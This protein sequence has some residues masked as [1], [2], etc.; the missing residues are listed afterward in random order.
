MKPTREGWDWSTKLGLGSGREAGLLGWVLGWGLGLGLGLCVLPERCAAQTDNF[1]D[2]NDE[3]WVRYDRTGTATFTF[4]EG[5]YRIQAASVGGA[6][7]QKAQV[8]SYRAEEY[9][10]FYAAV[11]LRGWDNDVRSAIGLFFRGQD[12]SPGWTSGYVLYWTPAVSGGGNRLFS[13]YIIYADQPLAAVAA[14]Y[15]TLDPNRTYRMVATG[16]G[17]LFE[18][19]MYDLADLTH[20]IASIS[21]RDALLPSLNLG[22]RGK[23]GLFAYSRNNTTVDVTFDN[24]VA[25][26]TDPGG[27]PA[28]G[29]AHPVPGMPQV[30]GRVPR[31]NQNLHPAGGGV[32]FTATTLG[33]AAIDPADIRMWLNG[34]DVS[35]QLAVG[36]AP[37]ARTVTYGGLVANEVY[38]GQ[39]VLTDAGGRTSTNEFSFDTFSENFLSSDAVPK[40]EAEDYNYDSGKYQNDPP[41]SGLTAGGAPVNGN[42]VGYFN[43]LGTPEVDY[44]DRRSNPEN[45]YRAYRV[46]DRVGTAAGSLYYLHIDPFQGQMTV[47][48]NDTPLAEHASLGLPDY[49]VQRTEG[50]EWLNYTR[51]FA[52]GRYHVW[53]R[54]SSI[55]GQD[56]LFAEVTGDRT[57]PNQETTQLGAFRLTNTGHISAYRYFPLLDEADQPQVLAWGGEKTFRLTVGGPQQDLTKNTVQ[58][59]YLIFVPARPS[60]VRLVNPER[61]SAGFR[62][63]F[64]SEAGVSYQLESKDTLAEGTWVSRSSAVI[65]NGA[66]KTMLDA[67]AASM[68][69]YRVVAQ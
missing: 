56:L 21:G 55:V 15:L 44:S 1:D 19:R 29:T 40:V 54:L 10:D 12:V 11:D 49:Q 57:Q 24:Y 51:V 47:S 6:E 50:G 53:A 3:G 64:L 48:T 58:L 7:E 59:N 39:I 20:P 65:G 9:T 68:R 14:T 25:A 34:G 27:V 4:P 31:A 2:A 45:D 63:S 43:L 28:P 33:G 18:G 13:I 52:P 26:A 61:D 23:C 32:A 5:G 67:G 35:A 17:D 30:V 37:N 38:A 60:P 22:Q 8:F 66:L 42:G 69:F 36:G 62:V 46:E 41:P 16:K